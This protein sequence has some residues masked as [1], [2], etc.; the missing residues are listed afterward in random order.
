MQIKVSHF[1]ISFFYP[2]NMKQ[3]C[4][5][6]RCYNLKRSTSVISET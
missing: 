4:K 6:L 2:N 3:P 1:C 5:G